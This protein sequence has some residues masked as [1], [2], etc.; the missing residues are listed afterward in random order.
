[1]TSK[2]GTDVQRALTLVSR[3]THAAWTPAKIAAEV[4]ASRRSV[5]RWIAGQNQPSAR[6]REALKVFIGALRQDVA[7]GPYR[8][9]ATDKVLA[10]ALDALR[11]TAERDRAAQ[12]EAELK[13]SAVKAEADVE[14]ALEADYQARQ[15]RRIARQRQAPVSITA[16]AEPFA[17]VASGRPA[18]VPMFGAVAA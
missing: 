17:V 11:T 18:E 2:I 15:A 6:N 9:S 4:G 3:A 5:Y 13:A 1:M 8:Q 7:F 14:A 16:Q 12:I 10:E